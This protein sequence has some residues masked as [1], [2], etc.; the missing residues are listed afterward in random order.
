MNNETAMLSRWMDCVKEPGVQVLFHW[1]VIEMES[2]SLLSGAMNFRAEPQ[3]YLERP[4]WGGAT[5]L[6]IKIML[7]KLKYVIV[8]IV[9]M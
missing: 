9:S 2:T 6:A 8:C 7:K 4:G 5:N 1:Q 3:T